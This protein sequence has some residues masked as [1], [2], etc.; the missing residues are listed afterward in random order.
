MSHGLNRLYVA[1]A[2]MLAFGLF[3][4]LVLLLQDA[5]PS[6]ASNLVDSLAGALNPAPQSALEPEPLAQIGFHIGR[7]IA[8]LLGGLFFL[9]H[10]VGDTRPGKK[11]SLRQW[12]ARSVLGAL[13]GNYLGP[14]LATA[15]LVGDL[16]APEITNAFIAGVLGYTLM[17]LVIDKLH[18]S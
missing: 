6:A 9:L 13:S 11:I 1:L 4:A 17:G 12:S 7:T 5:P 2:P 8:G 16:P 18:L 10:Q 3:A 14:I 15:P